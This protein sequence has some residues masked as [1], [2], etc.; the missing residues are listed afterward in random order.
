MVHGLPLT[1]FPESLFAKAPMYVGTHRHS[2]RYTSS[3][4]MDLQLWLVS[5]PMGPCVS[6]RTIAFSVWVGLPWPAWKRFSRDHLWVV[7]PRSW[8][9]VFSAVCS[10]ID[11]CHSEMQ[12]LRGWSK[13]LVYT[14]Q[15]RW[16]LILSIASFLCWAGVQSKTWVKKPGRCI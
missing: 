9:P 4:S 12:A 13:T 2:T 14:D 6:G 16:L 11:R 15:F 5:G 7:D 10:Y 1:A 8:Q 3:M